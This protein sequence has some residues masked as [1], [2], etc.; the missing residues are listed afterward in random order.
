MRPAKK[1][2]KAWRQLLVNGEW[3]TTAKTRTTKKG[4]YKFVVK[5]ARPKAV[6][7]YRI[8]V[9]RKKTVVGVSPE[10]TVGLR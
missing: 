8:L 6:G 5:K 10:F 9:V 2:L 4:R 1:G 7:T 3:Q